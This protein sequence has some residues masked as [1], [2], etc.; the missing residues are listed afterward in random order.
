M[1]KLNRIFGGLNIE[2]EPQQKI[3]F[4][5]VATM[6]SFWLYKKFRQFV[7]ILMCKKCK[8]LK[9][10]LVYLVSGICLILYIYF[11]SK[12]IKTRPVAST[13][14]KL[15]KFGLEQL[16]NQYIKISGSCLHI[17][18][19]SLLIK[20]CKNISYIFNRFWEIQEIPKKCWR[21]P[22]VIDL[23]TCSLL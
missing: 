10:W 3:F 16:F 17:H 21:F 2:T 23:T 12:L 1:F 14:T 13:H 7:N 9:Y 19:I 20:Q 4:Q 18:Q 6:I 11:M 22:K 5:V 8:Y 15:Y